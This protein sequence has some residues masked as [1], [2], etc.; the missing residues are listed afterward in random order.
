MYRLCIQ[1]ITPC[2]EKQK[3]NDQRVFHITNVNKNHSK[4]ILFYKTTSTNEKTHG[5]DEDS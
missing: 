2:T 4:L 3:W 1:I 5:L